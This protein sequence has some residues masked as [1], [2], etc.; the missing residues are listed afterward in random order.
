MCLCSLPTCVELPVKAFSWITSMP[1]GI[2]KCGFFLS[3]A[4]PFA[5]SPGTI[6]FSVPAGFPSWSVTVI[7]F[8][9]PICLPSGVILKSS[10][11]QVKDSS[12]VV[13]ESVEA[14]LDSSDAVT[15]LSSILFV[16][17]LVLLTSIRV[18]VS[19]AFSEFSASVTDSEALE[20]LEDLV[21]F[22]VSAG[23]ADS[24]ELEELILSEDFTEVLSEVPPPCWFY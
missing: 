8:L 20:D 13:V 14:A 16:W 10:R 15:L 18:W 6:T 3:F 7:S 24:V 9:Y 23:F 4:R 21:D 11:V 12:F 1:S 22:V 19:I 2:T 5:L 17:R